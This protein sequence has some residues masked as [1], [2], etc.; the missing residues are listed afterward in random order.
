MSMFMEDKV[1]VPVVERLRASADDVARWAVALAGIPLEA[2]L[3]A[4]GRPAEAFGRVLVDVARRVC[5]T[6][7]AQLV[8]R[9]PGLEAA[10]VEAEL[11]VAAV[12]WLRDRADEVAASSIS[13]AR[14][15]VQEGQRHALVA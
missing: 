7:G 1:E 10:D 12:E 4:V 3:A 11:V 14:A 2:E 5:A 8:A 13:F 9:F 6:T 15:A